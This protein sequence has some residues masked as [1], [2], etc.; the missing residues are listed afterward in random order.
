MSTLKGTDLLAITRPSGTDAGTYKVAVSDLPGVVVSDTAPTS[1]EEGDLWY[2]T[3]SARL[4]CWVN[5]GSTTQWADV[6]QPGGGGG[7]SNWTRAGTTLSPATAGDD[8]DLG[9]GDL[10]AAAG[11]FSGTVSTP[12]FDNTI[13]PI[14][15]VRA[16]AN[17][18]IDGSGAININGQGNIASVRQVGNEFEFTFAT[19]MSSTNYAVTAMAGRLNDANQFVG[20][21]QTMTVNN[22]K[23]GIK[24]SSAS[25]MTTNLLLM[26]MVVM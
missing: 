24:D 2:D 7:A 1:P 8:V 14:F 10:S 18:T 20:S 22:F 21:D 15:G 11:T 16:W 17:V 12:N 3:V 5:D 6:T 23:I 9:T 25:A 4:F 26:V 19:A 13:A